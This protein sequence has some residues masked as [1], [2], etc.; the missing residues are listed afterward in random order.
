MNPRRQ[1]SPKKQR[2]SLGR[3]GGR[4]QDRKVNIVN[5]GVNLES[6][7][8]KDNR[9]GKATVNRTGMTSEMRECVCSVIAHTNYATVAS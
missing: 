2:K 7:L 8:V 1:S 4:Y 3:N 5:L 9:T 6:F